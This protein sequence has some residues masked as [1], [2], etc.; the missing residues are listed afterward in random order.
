LLRER[1]A[2]LQARA[3][4]SAAGIHINRTAVVGCPKP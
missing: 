3:A 4:A 2:G 1:R